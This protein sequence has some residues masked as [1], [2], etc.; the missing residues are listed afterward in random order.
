MAKSQWAPNA[1]ETCSSSPC[2]GG[3]GRDVASSELFLGSVFGKLFFDWLQEENS[4]AP[5]NHLCAHSSFPQLKRAYHET[6]LTPTQ[7]RIWFKGL[8]ASF[9]LPPHPY[10][11]PALPSI[12]WTP[13]PEIYLGLYEPREKAQSKGSQSVPFLP[14]IKPPDYTTIISSPGTLRLRS[15]GLQGLIAQTPPQLTSGRLNMKYLVP[16]GPLPTVPHRA[17]SIAVR[18]TAIY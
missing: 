6:R 18:N 17:H 1:A 16:R 11:V 4:Q 12:C 7:R 8:W 5:H 15:M 3:A 10:P 14:S 13:S 9:S 2:S